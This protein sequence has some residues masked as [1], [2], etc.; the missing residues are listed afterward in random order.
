MIDKHY[1]YLEYIHNQEDVCRIKHFLQDWEPV[2]MR[3]LGAMEKRGL[4][5][6]RVKDGYVSIESNGFDL[7]ESEGP[8]V[9]HA[10]LDR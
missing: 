8:K 7:L 3:V 5:D 4:V 9:R 6:V 2:G 1:K 10:R